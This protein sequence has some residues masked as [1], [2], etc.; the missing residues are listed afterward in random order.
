MPGTEQVEEPSTPPEQLAGSAANDEGLVW[1]LAMLC[2][3]VPDEAARDRDTSAGAATVP[4]S[5]PLA[6]AHSQDSRGAVEVS[7]KDTQRADNSVTR[8]TSDIASSEKTV[9][10]SAAPGVGPAAS[11]WTT[12]DFDDDDD[13]CDLNFALG[14]VPEPPA[15]VS[16]SRP[17]RKIVPGWRY[18][19]V[20]L[21]DLDLT[22]SVATPTDPSVT[23]TPSDV[24][25]SSDVDHGAV[26]DEA[27]LGPRY[28][29]LSDLSLWSPHDA[30]GTT[31]TDSAVHGGTPAA[32]DDLWSFL[33]KLTIEDTG[34]VEAAVVQLSPEQIEHH[35]LER[36][37]R[38]RKSAEQVVMWGAEAREKCA[39]RCDRDELQDPAQQRLGAITTGALSS[40][41]SSSSSL[42]STVPNES[43]GIAIGNSLSSSPDIDMFGQRSAARPA[44]PYS[45]ITPDP[46]WSPVSGSTWRKLNSQE[47][48]VQHVRSAEAHGGLAITCQLSEEFHA[49]VL[50][51]PDATATLTS[52]LRRELAAEDI[53]DLPY[54]IAWDWSPDTQ[55]LHIHG[56]VVRPEGVA[57]DQVRRAFVKA[58]GRW[59]GKAAPRQWD[60]QPVYDPE[61]WAGYLL[62]TRKPA[63]RERL[64]ELLGH[65]RLIRVSHP[66]TQLTGGRHCRLSASPITTCYA[67]SA[68]R[69]S[70]A[71]LRRAS[72]G[73]AGSGRAPTTRQVPSAV[74]DPSRKPSAHILSPGP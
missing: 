9:D 29:D 22:S 67:M 23:L 47:R 45:M 63:V 14:H 61:R 24:P 8:P 21:T 60:C 41:S 42:S 56:V 51:S 59:Q 43:D 30:E 25:G 10:S 69:T 12:S 38:E 37:Q 1:E 19:D 20:E 5:Q 4:V 53:E 11:S 73:L 17:K 39:D 68:R 57:I 71:A 74:Y 72:S 35:Q 62:K 31:A 34:T 52:N 28:D 64:V 6:G 50:R 3:A 48:L 7:V 13:L 49:T 18:E 58:C 65:A 15:Q 27:N 33:D 32:E 2:D 54:L 16:L 46:A 66:M 40:S 44:S 70:A 36:Q 55:R 26:G